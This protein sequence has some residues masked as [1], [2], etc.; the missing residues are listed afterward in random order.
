[1]VIFNSSKFSGL[2]RVGRSEIAGLRQIVLR[3]KNLSHA[4]GG[5]NE[6]QVAMTEGGLPLEAPKKRAGGSVG[7]SE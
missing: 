1:M 5:A 6:F 3:I 4:M 7:I 2:V